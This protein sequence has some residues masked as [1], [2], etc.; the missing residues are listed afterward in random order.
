MDAGR[1][2]VQPRDNRDKTVAA[3]LRAR[4]VGRAQFM[5]TRLGRGR[6]S[7]EMTLVSTRCI[8]PPAIATAIEMISAPTNNAMITGTFHASSLDGTALQ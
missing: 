4:V 3:G 1:L 2:I 5:T 7:S 6:A 8:Y